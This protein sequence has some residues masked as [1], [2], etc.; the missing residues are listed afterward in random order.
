VELA[1]FTPEQVRDMVT[2]WFADDPK[3]SR[4]FLEDFGQ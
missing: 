4:L 3:K 2:K 1:D